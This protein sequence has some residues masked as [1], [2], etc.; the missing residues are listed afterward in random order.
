MYIF[1]ANVLLICCLLFD[2]VSTKSWNLSINNFV[3]HNIGQYVNII[4]KKLH[5][6]GIMFS[7]HLITH[8][9]AILY[10]KSMKFDM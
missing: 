1:F 7:L 6:H 10:R 8:C 2:I 5:F 4:F 3:L 9:S